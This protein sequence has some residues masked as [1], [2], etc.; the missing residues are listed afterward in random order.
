[1]AAKTSRI[2]RLRKIITILLALAGA[3][4]MFFYTYCDTACAYL[5]GDLLGLDLKYVGIFFTAVIA[6]LSGTGKVPAARTLLAGGLGGEIFLLGFQ[7]RENIF[8]PYCLAFAACIAAAYGVNYE[9]PKVTGWKR[10]FYLPGEVRLAPAEKSYPLALFMLAGYVFMA[11]TFSGSALPAYAADPGPPVYGSGDK[12]IR[13]YTDY[14]CVPCRKTESR[15]EKLLMDIVRKKKGRIRFIDTPIHK[16]TILYAK[17]FIY[18][19]GAKPDAEFRTVLQFRKALFEAAEKEIN[20]ED[21][22]KE[23]L[24]A[25]DIPFTQVDA[26]PYFKSYTGY[27]QEDRINSTPT[28]VVVSREDKTA[29]GGADEIMNALEKIRGTTPRKNRP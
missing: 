5:K 19:L 11:L 6:L 18:I 25:R 14:F 15:I 10:L 4:I 23:F 27:I 2:F 26:R 22:L 24:Q 20:G 7:I 12:E 8:C 16:E 29:H 13:I 21:S 28:V 9:V 3:G 17:Y 1:M